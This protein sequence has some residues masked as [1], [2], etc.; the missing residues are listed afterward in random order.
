MNFDEHICA[1]HM[2]S[3]DTLL[4]LTYRD[5]VHEFAKMCETNKRVILA[6]LTADGFHLSLHRSASSSE[7]HIEYSSRH[8]IGSI[9]DAAR[10]GIAEKLGYKQPQKHACY[11]LN[12]PLL[13]TNAS[14]APFLTQRLMLDSFSRSIPARRARLPRICIPVSAT[15]FLLS[16][17]FSAD[18][19]TTRPESITLRTS[20]GVLSLHIET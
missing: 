6:L 17:H 20:L 7:T 12:A 1:F 11:V 16:F 9:W 2:P 5:N 4:C 19:S 10:V 15:S 13:E 14:G 3:K 18:G 8:P